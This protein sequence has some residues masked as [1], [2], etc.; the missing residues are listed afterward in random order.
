MVLFILSLLLGLW[1]K[2]TASFKKK[3][4]HFVVKKILQETKDAP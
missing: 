2:S 1:I 4:Q 3:L